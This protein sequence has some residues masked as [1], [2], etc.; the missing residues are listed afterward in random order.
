MTVSPLFLL[1][2]MISRAGACTRTRADECTFP[3]ADQRPRTRTN[4]GADAD[5]LGSLLFPGFRVAPIS[6]LA[7]RYGNRHSER[8][9]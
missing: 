2:V 7:A 8:E 3:T 4:G 1:V 6:A 9:H 5:A